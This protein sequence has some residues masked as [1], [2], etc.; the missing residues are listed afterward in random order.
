MIFR[1]GITT[2]ANTASTSK[3]RTDLKL[4]HGIVT[5]IDV[6]F[7]PGPQ[8]LL[9]L[10]I[11]DSLHQIWPFNPNEDFA[12]DFVNISFREFIPVITEPYEFQ[13]YTWNEDDTYD[14]YLIIRIGIL[15]VNVAA[16]WL[17]SFTE[18]I[19]AALGGL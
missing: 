3:Q 8:G 6:Q 11:T 1:F 4:A 15:P 5:Q 19:K 14:H 17:M 12:S 10:Q 13:A 18:R 7:P 9:H 16:P 2:S